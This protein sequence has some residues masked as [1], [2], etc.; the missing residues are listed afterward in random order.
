MGAG[1]A[2]I[3][4]AERLYAENITNILII[5][6]QDYIGGRTKAVNFS[7][8]G[9]NIGA[10]WI[11]GA[12]ID[13]NSSNCTWYNET[14]PMLIAA[15]KYDFS[16]V[17]S[18]YTK[19][20]ILDFGGTVHNTT[21][22]NKRYAKFSEAM[23][24]AWNIYENL[25]STHE[26]QTDMSYF[27]LLRLC[28]WSAPRTAIDKT[29]QW[30]NFEFEAQKVRW[31]SGIDQYTNEDRF[32]TYDRYGSDDLFITDPRGYQGIIKAI[33]NEFLDAENEA[34]IIFNSPIT[35]IEYSDTV[36]FTVFC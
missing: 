7:N 20:E 19:G 16:Y 36:M 5:E 25:T 27:A 12:C 11:S 13:I 9:F 34:Q 30:V 1:A 21:N 4:A 3:G 24:C 29:V 35:T 6:A 17:L 15:E 8:I 2:G 18:D 10:S 14:N 33:A 28:G 32:G 22:S 26:Y 31:S 23:D